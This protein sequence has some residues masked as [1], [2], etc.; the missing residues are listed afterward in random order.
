MQSIL[1]AK[2]VEN[3]RLIFI[4]DGNFWSVFFCGYWEPIGFSRSGCLT[5]WWAI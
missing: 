3:M 2:L 1:L 4:N 5:H